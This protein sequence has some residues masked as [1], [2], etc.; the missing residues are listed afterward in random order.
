MQQRWTIDGL[1]DTW[2]LLPTERELLGN[3][4]GATRLGSAVM[5]KAFQHEGRFPYNVHEVPESVIE[6]MARQVEVP[7]GQYGAYNWRSRNSTYQR[8]EIRAYCGFRV[9]TREDADMLTDWLSQSVV[10]RASRV[11]AVMEAAL[12]WLRQQ[13]LE[14]P[15]AGR[16]QRFV[17]SAER[18][19]DMRL[20]QTTHDHLSETHREQLDALLDSTVSPE[21]AADER[22]G[23]SRR[24][25]LQD[26]RTN[27]EKRG[28]DSVEQQIEKLRLLRKLQLPPGLFMDVSPHVLARYRERAATTSPSHFRAQA[29]PV[30]LT[31]LS[32]FC[33]TRIAELTDSL[34]T[35]LTDMVHHINV[36]AERRVERTFIREFRKVNHKERLWERLLEAALD[37][38][39][40]TVREVLFPVAG[41]QTLRDLLRE[42]R[43]KGGYRQQVHVA[44]RGTYR[45]HYRRMIPW[46]LTEL[47]F[48]S[49]NAR[50]QP[51]IQALGL[52]KRYV[53]SHVRIYPPEE[54]IPVG[55]VIDKNIRDLILETGPD[56]T[57]RVNRV[58]YELCVLSALRDAVRSREIWVVGADQYR[59]PDQDLP[60]DF[61]EQKATYFSALGQPQEADT[62]VQGLELRLK[63]A[64]VML[65]DGLSKN[66]GVR[67]VAR[68]GGRF[69]V[70]PLTAQPEPPFYD[71][72]KGEVGR[73]FWNTQLLDVLMEAD[74]RAGITPHFG[75]FLTRENISREDLQQRLLLCLFGLGTNTGLKRVAAGQ[76]G[77]AQHNLQY[78][79]R[80]FIHRDA[81]RAANAAVVNATLEA[82]HPDIWGDGTTSCASDAKKY[83][84]WDGNLRTQ[85]SIR[86][87]GNGVMIYWHVERR[88]TCIYSSMKACSSSEVAAMIEGVLRH[89]TTM[90][91]EKNYVDTH[92]QSEVGFAFT[93][94]LGF[95]LMPRLAD[96]AHQRLYLPSAGF[97]AQVPHLTAVLAQRSIRWDL[98]REQ[99]EP[100]VK[101]ATALRLGLADPESIL[102]RFTRANAQHPTYAALCELGKVLRT[103]FVCEY[104]HRLELRREIHEGLNVIE[105]W[106]GTTDFVFFGKTGEI[107]T[108]NPETQEISMLALHLL[109]NSM[110]FINTLM[111][112]RVLSE[113]QWRE[114]MT[115][116]DWRALSPLMHH[117][118]NP[119]GEFKL[120]LSRRLKLDA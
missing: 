89:C 30:R 92:G 111:I 6:Y 87:G 16:L 103:I 21:D 44:V 78:V 113:A 31:L 56:G 97:G 106:N 18:Q 82:R 14:P 88:A 37:N 91:V 36:R 9:C 93:H 51:V 19:Y 107:S 75:S 32:A 79:R 49:N 2:T 12:G 23:D 112:Q 58:N 98:I 81:L 38:P 63:D 119:Y 84:A 95:Q 86:Y 33:V 94:L 109:Q 120:D 102:Q 73:Q 24:S 59:D 69:V 110:V 57:A 99:Y 1:I 46:V 105:T 60:Q 117:H 3:K 7:L 11:S 104:L 62:F 54:V 28:V 43:E 22:D 35:H 90:K 68:D 50:H 85:R 64:L 115:T 29:A 25:A 80:H 45:N 27:S 17:D 74:Q 52:L 116:A 15:S 77:V 26:L 39:D 96:I 76:D 47:E 34:V 42:Y 101:Y 13:R 20:C 70:T 5:L 61:E 118:I 10:P 53:D 8:Q 40:G 41:E 100:M 48:R 71:T 114:R 65:H 67:V 66:P 72:L 55:G 83:S 4:T 108:N